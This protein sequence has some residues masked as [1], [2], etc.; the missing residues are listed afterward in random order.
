[1]FI[2]LLISFLGTVI[3]TTLEIRPKE[4]FIISKCV[5]CLTFWILMIGPKG[6]KFN[7]NLIGSV[8]L[9]LL[10]S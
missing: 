5:K 1:M 3:F 6:K 8:G 9:G 2:T 4:C 7:K 10:F